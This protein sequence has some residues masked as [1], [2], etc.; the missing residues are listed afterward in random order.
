MTAVGF[1]STSPFFVNYLDLHPGS[2]LFDRT[3]N[4]RRLR[5]LRIVLVP[6][7]SWASGLAGDHGSVEDPK[8]GSSGVPSKSNQS[9]GQT[10]FLL[11]QGILAAKP[12][13]LINDSLCFLDLPRVELVR[14]R[15]KESVS[16]EVWVF[17]RTLRL[18][19]SL[20][21]R[22]LKTIGVLIDFQ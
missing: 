14:R 12:M 5:R 6:R 3:S 19:C 7:F 10:D 1:L 21:L 4:D 22:Q 11:V 15:A 16:S 9:G 20:S 18:H 17:R 2:L 8:L 13:W